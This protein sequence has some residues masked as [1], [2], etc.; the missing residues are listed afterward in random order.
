M[1]DVLRAL[2][3]AHYL[4]S[5]CSFLRTLTVQLEEKRKLMSLKRGER[6]KRGLFVVLAKKVEEVLDD[7]GELPKPLQRARPELVLGKKM[8]MSVT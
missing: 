5:S 7:S 3:S 8:V 6:M 4:I 1:R 2:P